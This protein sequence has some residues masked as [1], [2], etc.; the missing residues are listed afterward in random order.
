MQLRGGHSAQLIKQVP[1]LDLGQTA[2]A[3]EQQTIDRRFQLKMITTNRLKF[4]QDNHILFLLNLLLDH[5]LHRQDRYQ[6]PQL[7]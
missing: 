4:G 2:Q 5:L 6:H 7:S 3:V 1:L